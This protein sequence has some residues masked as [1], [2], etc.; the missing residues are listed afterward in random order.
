MIIYITYILFTIGGL[1]LMKIGGNQ[2]SLNINKQMLGLSIGWILILA[3]AMY[4]VSFLIW[5]R[6]VT[7][8]DLTYIMP[9]TS[10]I[11]NVLSVIAGIIIFKENLS[12]IQI[13]GIAVTI[14][15]IIMI[16]IK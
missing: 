2:L 6:I 9:I 1:I 13:A 11:T 4:G 10:A 5:S 12:I 3:F 16:N 15:G 8:N 7:K 14:L